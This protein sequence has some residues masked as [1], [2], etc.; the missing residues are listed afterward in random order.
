LLAK[1]ISLLRT[2]F[3]HKCPACGQG[4]IYD[5]LLEVRTKCQNCGQILKDHDAG[6]IS[7]FIAM[8][9]AGIII[10]A[11]AFVV[12]IYLM[13]PLWLHVIIWIPI[14]VGL[15]IFLL[16]TIKSWL[17]GIKYRHNAAPQEDK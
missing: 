2:T 3:C 8:F 14:T 10:T 16:K 1:N 13:V 6:D 17:V 15:S 12:E 4:D 9:I 7:V 5:K 11:L